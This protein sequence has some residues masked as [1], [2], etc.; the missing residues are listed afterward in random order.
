VI[1][2]V[3]LVAVARHLDPDLVE[4]V[5]RPMIA[6]FTNQQLRDLGRDS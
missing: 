4:S 3:R 2:N 5:Y 1:A 6:W